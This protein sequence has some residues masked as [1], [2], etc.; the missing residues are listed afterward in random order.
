MR[1]VFLW[2]SRHYTLDQVAVGHGLLCWFQRGPNERWWM[3]PYKCS[4]PTGTL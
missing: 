4:S 1:N 3:D 2:D